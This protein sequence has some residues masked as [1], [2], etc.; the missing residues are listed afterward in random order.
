MIGMEQQQMEAA[1]AKQDRDIDTMLEDL[2][3]EIQ[4]GE[5]LA[6][7]EGVRTSRL[8]RLNSRDMNYD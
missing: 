8:Q 7:C 5:F 1:V 4:E 6:Y 3:D 2:N